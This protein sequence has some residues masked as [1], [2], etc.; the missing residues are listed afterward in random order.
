MKEKLLYTICLKPMPPKFELCLTDCIMDG[1][2]M[3]CDEC[4]HSE[5]VM[6]EPV[7]ATTKFKNPEVVVLVA[8]NRD[9]YITNEGHGIHK[10][11]LEIDGKG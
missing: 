10:S 6:I 9:K 4:H 11:R 3:Y 5:D 2:D 7:L 8:K 1:M